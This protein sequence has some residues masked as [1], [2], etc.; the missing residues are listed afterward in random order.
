MSGPESFNLPLL[1]VQ[2]VVIVVVARLAGLA[3]AAVGQPRVIGEVVAGLVLG[4]SV[5]GAVAPAASAALFPPA[6]LGFLSALSQIGL[7]F[8]MFLVG[9]EIDPAHLRERARI[10]IVTSNASIIAPFLLGAT[11]AVLLYHRLAP[12]GVEFA[13]FAMFVGAAMSVTAFPVLARILAERGLTRTRL[14]TIAIACAA[15]ND[16]TAWCILAVIVVLVRGSRP[17]ASL[18][19]T[20]GGAIIYVGLML[21]IGRRT[22]RIL[23]DRYGPKGS[24]SPDLIAVV[25]VAVLVSSWITERLGI[26]ALFGAFLIGSIMPRTDALVQGLRG[27]LEDV[28]VV[29]LLPLFFAFTGLR[30]TIGLIEGRE[31]WMMCGL[32]TLVAIVGKLG[33]TAIAARVTG[34]EWR[35]ALALGTLMN[36]RGLMELVILN[37]GLDVG[38]I[39]PTLF[40]MMV[41]MAI[42]TTA[43]TTPV[44]AWLHPVVPTASP[45]LRRAS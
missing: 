7:L 31:L 28:M 22:L 35:E 3:L 5:L 23:T 37:V 16:I 25:L 1:L 38:M 19:L 24:L 30:T 45:L 43:M 11:L 33:G 20:A 39:S 8:F 6:S 36:T 41:V 15:V 13:G 26:H 44:L 12:A 27:R 21:T 18:W 29:L 42:T 2:I 10:A 40:A 14:G 34:L 32:V 9:L 4:P 17:D